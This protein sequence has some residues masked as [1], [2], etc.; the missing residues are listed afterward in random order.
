[1]K[2]LTLL[3]LIARL[4]GVRD[5]GEKRLVVRLQPRDADWF[6]T[7]DLFGL[8][9]SKDEVEL[10]VQIN[11]SKLITDPDALIEARKVLAS[12]TTKDK[13]S[14]IARE[15]QDKKITIEAKVK[16]WQAK[17][18]LSQAAFYRAIN[19]PESTQNKAVNLAEK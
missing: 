6:V 18:G 4:N 17:T 16:E 3:D 5:P 19:R 14:F 1:M 9:I 8:K 10:I 11:A 15:I 13:E 12:P 7:E 2:K